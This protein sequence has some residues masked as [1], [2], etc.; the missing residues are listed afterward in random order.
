MAVEWKIEYGAE[1][2]TFSEWG[3]DE[4]ATLSLFQ[5]AVDQLPLTQRNADYD[6]DPI[7][8][9]DSTVKLHRVEDGTSVQ[10]FVGRVV[11]IIRDG[12]Q[13]SESI[14]YQVLG[15]WWYLDTLTFK[16]AWSSWNNGSQS[17]ETKYTSHVLLGQQQDGTRLNN[18][19]QIKTVIDYCIAKGAPFQRDTGDEAQLP[20]ADIPLDE[21]RDITCGEA[22]RRLARWTPDLLIWF[23]YSTATPTIRVKRRSALTSKTLDVST[24]APNEK[25]NIRAKYELQRPAVA[26]KY[27]IDN[28]YNGQKLVTVQE[29]I[30]PGGATG[31]EFKAFNA[32][33][34]LQ[35][36]SVT[37][38]KQQIT[39]ATINPASASWWRSREA[40][41]NDG[42]ITILG[43]SD[44]VNPASYA[45]ELT[46]GQVHP[47]MSS[48]VEEVTIRA[49]LRIQTG[50]GNI[51]TKP[52]AYTLTATS[53][54]GGT[55]S[56]VSTF[57]AGEPVPSGLAQHIY[58]AVNT[59]QFEGQFIAL[60]EEITG[61]ANV[62]NK[63]NLSGGRSA[64][65]SMN[66][67]IWNAQFNLQSGRTT[68]VFGPHQHLGLGDLITLSKVNRHRF[69]YTNPAT[70]NTAQNG[71]SGNWQL[72]KDGPK[73]NSNSGGGAFEKF[74]IQA[75]DP[76]DSDDQVRIDIDP[77]DYRS[78]KKGIILKLREVS[79]C[80]VDDNGTAHEKK[81]TV[82]ASENYDP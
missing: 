21:A 22:I 55:Y 26:L 44:I 59:L 39:V 43:I 36:Y 42:T 15:L 74:T 34:N 58:D 5:Q 50:Q 37:H 49:K 73:K 7:F 13:D 27:E 25:V 67:V 69:V 28:N 31:D 53:L 65:T 62:G 11:D 51:E 41:L 56:T 33:I 14:R 46:N 81:M 75:G 40:H 68:L 38:L 52:V 6:A 71:N 70:Q 78:T 9:V 10:W 61:L 64:W 60:E 8:D 16:Q 20:D 24:G 32:T 23:D 80:E 4:S 35:G 57:D 45:N 29:D 79:V 66:A 17:L 12:T 2:K 47:W 63:L 82:I 1:T 77:D 30:H 48:N 76:N 19:A 18:G 3:L 54:S 72:G